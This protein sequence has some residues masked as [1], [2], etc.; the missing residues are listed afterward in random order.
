M[1][2]K[3]YETGVKFVVIERNLRID[4]IYSKFRTLA[5]IRNVHMQELI[6]L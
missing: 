1:K 6:G 2:S 5:F 4:T 3:N